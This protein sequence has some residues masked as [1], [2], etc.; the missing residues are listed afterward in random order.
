MPETQRLFVGI[1]IGD[2][3]TDHLSVTADD[4]R[5]SLGSSVRW[6]RPELYH[7]TLVFLGDQ[8]QRDA[9]QVGQAVRATAAA[10]QPFDLELDALHRLGGHEHGALV[11]GVRDPSGRLQRVRARLDTELRQRGIRFDSKPLVPHVTLAR[12]RRRQGRIDFE[13]VD[14][15]DAPPLAANALTLV[16]SLLLPEGPKYTSLMKIRLGGH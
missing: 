1:D 11:A 12:P 10:G 5:D 13:P 16:R 7:I 6:V 2:A 14:L 4:L 9:E 15:S 8:S 3:W